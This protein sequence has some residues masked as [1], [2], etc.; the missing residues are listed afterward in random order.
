MAKIIQHPHKTLRMKARVVADEDFGSAKLKKIIRDM[1]AALDR[2]DDGVALAAPQIDVPLKIFVIAPKAYD[3]ATM[4]VRPSGRV[5]PPTN[6]DAAI[7]KDRPLVFINPEIVKQSR[8]K[9]MMQEGCLSVRGW[10]GDIRRSIKTMVRAHDEN[11]KEFTVG[12]SGLIA[13]IFQH[14]VDHL[15]GTLFI[16]NAKNLKEITPDNEQ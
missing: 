1:R 2:E 8:E 9:M 12:A 10:Y 14:E 13:E 7:F 3:Y 6:T 4:K 11:G 5:N 15:N 16:D